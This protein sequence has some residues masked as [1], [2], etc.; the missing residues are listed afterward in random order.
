MK[1]K[2]SN[3]GGG[4]SEGGRR[5]NPGGEDSRRWWQ[6]GLL[7]FSLWIFWWVS[8]FSLNLVL[9]VCWVFHFLLLDVFSLDVT[10]GS[11]REQNPNTQKPWNLNTKN[12]TPNILD[13]KWETNAENRIN[14]VIKQTPKRCS[15]GNKGRK[16]KKAITK[17][18]TWANWRQARV[19]AARILGTL[20]KYFIQII[21]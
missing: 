21:I 16:N 10:N 17:S 2:K 4:N 1:T 3:Q 20:L 13:L 15:F 12:K 6:R 8:W 14:R 7:M 9:G 19:L 5:L 18:R 11:E